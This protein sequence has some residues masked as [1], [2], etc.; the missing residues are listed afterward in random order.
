MVLFLSNLCYNLQL[1]GEKNM[2]KFC[3]FVNGSCRSDCTFKINTTATEHGMSGCLI[4]VKLEGVNENQ[5]NQLMQ[6]FNK[7]H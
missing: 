6:L 1:G 3:P 5:S 2:G 4:A 7:S